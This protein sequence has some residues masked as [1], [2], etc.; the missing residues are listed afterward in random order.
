[1]FS[2]VPGSEQIVKTKKRRKMMKC[3]CVEC[4]VTKTR[5]LAGKTQGS[6]FDELMV[7]GS[8]ALRCKRSLQLRMNRCQSSNKI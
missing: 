4:G 6:G 8:A 5:F 1:M 7:K 2:C 3:K